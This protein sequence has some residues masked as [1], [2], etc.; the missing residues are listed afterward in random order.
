MPET[1]VTIVGNLTAD[2][3]LR[4]T[5]NGKSVANITIASTPRY[6]DKATQEWKDG[7]P[8]F[9]RATVWQEAAEYVA[10][11]LTKGTRV[12]ATGKL[13]QR[14]FETR[15]GEKRSSIEL[16]IEEIGPS[17][18]YAQAS[19]VKGARSNSNWNPP[20]DDDAPF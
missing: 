19:V 18:R 12:I 17:L 7:E 1:Q 20:Q 11:S 2:P 15:E 5:G 10:E 3:E 6:L 16:E 8:L 14:N 13:K 9:L 4:F